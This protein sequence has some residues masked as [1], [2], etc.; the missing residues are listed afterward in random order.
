VKTPEQKAA[1]SLLDEAIKG[2]IKAYELTDEQSVLTEYV[3]AG[4]GLRYDEEG[5][6]ICDFFLA[7]REGQCRLP[8]ALGLLEMGKYEL[9]HQKEEVD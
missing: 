8:T 7:F 5:D 4:E 1:D 2:V 6:S 9:Q 3:I